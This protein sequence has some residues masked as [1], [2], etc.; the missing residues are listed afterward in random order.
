MKMNKL[1]NDKNKVLKKS[2]LPPFVNS[3]FSAV[4]PGL[5]QM[6]AREIKRGVILLMSFVTIGGLLAWRISIAGRRYEEIIVKIQKAFYLEPI[7]RTITIL[8]VCYYLWIIID[9]YIVANRRNQ[10]E[11]YTN[12][13]AILFFTI[14]LFFVLGWQIGKIDIYSLVTRADDAVPTLSHVIWPWK[15]AIVYPEEFSIITAEVEAPC[16]ETPFPETE[17]VEGEPFLHVSPTCGNPSEVDGTA[18]TTY[19][20]TGKD[21]IPSTEVEIWWRDPIGNEF[22]QRQEGEYVVF[23][24]DEDGNYQGE[25]I[26]PYR[27]L[28][29]SAGEGPKVWFLQ[30]RQLETVGAAK[31][32]EELKL[33]VEKMIETIIIGMMATFFGIIFAL[34]L[35]FLAARNLMTDNLISRIVY[36][37]VRMILNVVRS[38]EPLIWAII[39][40]IV[41]GLGPFAGIIALTVHS[42][43]ALAKMYSESIEN[44]DS[45]PIEAI[46]ATG[47]NWLQTVAYAVIPQIIPPFVSFTVYRWDINIRMSTVIGLVGGGGIGFLLSQWIRLLD[48]RSAGMAV[49]FIALTVMI[50]DY[51]SA[52][53]RERFI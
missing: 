22:R 42:M 37:I 5:G 34:P 27:I 49:W 53:I 39:A 12:A 41:V 9:A 17:Q 6:F 21:F 32:S 29:P 8:F 23:T 14:A 46:H 4:L 45:G 1:A 31:I 20:L 33:T 48:Y 30:A 16:S 3:I 38:I 7:L 24:P 35:S 43:A 2:L 44:I 51:A 26:M 50:L 18:G 36:Y 52:E 47:A 13:A 40:V 11:K 15:S 28:P 25:I 19:T 10:N